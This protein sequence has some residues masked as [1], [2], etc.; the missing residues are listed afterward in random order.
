MLPQT[1]NLK[2]TVMPDNVGYTPG[3]GEKIASRDVTYSGEAVKAQAVGL[4]T[5]EG[6]DYVQPITCGC[7]SVG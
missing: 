2:E 3:S 7:K 1:L 4:V 6:P 5:F